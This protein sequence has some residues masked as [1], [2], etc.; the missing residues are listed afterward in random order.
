V[1]SRIGRRLA[2]TLVIAASAS[3]LSAA[4]ASAAALTNVQWS[5]SNNANN[6]TGVHYTYQ[7]TAATTG[8][9]DT[10]TFTVPA[11]TAGTP[12]IVANY[13]IGA[14]SVGLAANTLTYTV[15]SPVS[16]SSGTP[17]LIEFGG[18]DNS[19]TLGSSTSTVTTQDNN[20]ATIDSGTSNANTITDANTVV[21]VVVAKSLTFTNDTSSFILLMDPALSALADETKDV[22]LTVR[23][24]ASQGYTLQANDTAAGLNVGSDTI[25]RFSNNGQTGHAAWGGSVNKFGYRLTPTITG[26]AALPGTMAGGDYAGYSNT[27]ETLVSR[28]DPTGNTPDQVVITNRVKIDYAQDA[29]TYGDTVT[30]TVTPSY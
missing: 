28:T 5:M 18:I 8:T 20:P 21:T 16:V 9:I 12:T 11:G 3:Y 2:L 24:N 30:Y 15:S 17:I 25:A 7:L 13:G 23:T 27:P 22:T 4:P 29:G 14:G 26:T 6:A 1:N 19:S 10:I